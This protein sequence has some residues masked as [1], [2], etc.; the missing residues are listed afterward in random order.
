MKGLDDSCHPFSATRFR[1]SFHE[2]PFPRG[3]LNT[4]FRLALKFLGSWAQLRDATLNLLERYHG[5]E[6]VSLLVPL[7]SEA[8][9]KL[10][11][12]LL[13][14]MSKLKLEIQGPQLRS[15]MAFNSD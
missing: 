9:A 15:G 6:T 3:E 13:E 4:V 11:T 12:T 7:L 5:F 2:L 14:Q 10:A 1:P 8:G